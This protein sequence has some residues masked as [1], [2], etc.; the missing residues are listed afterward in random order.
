MSHSPLIQIELDEQKKVLTLIIFQN[1]V[2]TT[3]DRFSSELDEIWEEQKL[4][5]KDWVQLVMD[6]TAINM[7]DSVGLNFLMKLIQKVKLKEVAIRAR[8]AS[9]LIYR[10]FLA[11]RIDRMMNLEMISSTAF[12]K[13]V[14]NENISY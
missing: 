2:S 5:Q 12:G 1:L 6:F 8:I 3:I 9:P 13:S 4:D 11:T 7:V 14:D 10:T